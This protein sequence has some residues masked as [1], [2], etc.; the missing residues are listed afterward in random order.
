MKTKLFS[1][2]TL[3]LC[4][5]S[6]AWAETITVTWLPNDMTAITKAGTASVENI[7]TVSN[8][9]TSTDLADPVMA[10]YD[11]KNWGNFLCSTAATKNYYSKDDYITFAVT[12]A[13]NYKFY[14]T[15][16][17]A[18]AVGAGTGEGGAKIFSTIQTEDGQNAVI[19][20]KNA[21]TPTEL[22]LTT[23]AS[24]S[25]D[26]GSTLYFYIHV[27][28]KA[29]T[30]GICLRDVT[31]TGTYESANMTKLSTPSI[32]VN[33]L[34]GAVTISDID[35]NATKVTYTTD[36]TDPT[37]SST[38]Y[39]TQ[40]TVDA[41]CTVKAI[42]IGDGA[43]YSNSNI[44]IQAAA[45]TVE[46]PV[47]T[48]YNGT[49]GITCATDGATIKYNFDNGETW[50]TYT[51]PFTLFESQTV[52]TKAESA[53]YKNNSST[54]N[55]AVT[56]A[57]AA[58]AG[59]SSIALYYDDITNFSL[60]TDGNNDVLT[61]KVGTDYEGFSITLDN[62]GYTG[63][64]IKAISFGSSI[65]EKTTLKG[66]NGRKI[67]IALPSNLRA[68]RIT[69]KSY[70]NGS[71]SSTSLW[72]NVGGTAYTDANEI[73]LQCIS[74]ADNPDVRVFSLD[75]LTSI[76]IVNNGAQQQCF[77]AT[78]DYTKYIP[79]PVE[80]ETEY[81]TNRTWDFSA[82][83]TTDEAAL[84]ANSDAFTYD[85]TNKV[86][87]NK[88]QWTKDTDHALEGTDGTDI[89]IA[90]GLLFGRA[91]G[92]ISASGFVLDVKNNCFYYSSNSNNY[93]KLPSL[94]VGTKVSINWKA[95]GGK[96]TLTVDNATVASG[97]T[98]EAASGTTI[99]SIFD[100][101]S[102]DPVVIKFSGKCLVYSI[103][104]SVLAGTILTTTA[105]MAGYRAFYDAENSYTVDENTTVYVVSANSSSS[106]TLK[107]YEG[108]IP[109][110][111]PVI[112]KTSADAESDGTYKMTLT[113]STS[114]AAFSV[115]N[116]LN[117]S[118]SGQNLENVYRL[119]YGEDGVGFYKYTTSSAAAG[120]V[121][122]ESAATARSLS[123]VFDDETT[124]I[125]NIESSMLN[126]DGY[127]NL[128][129]QRV[130]QPRKGLY[131]VNGK[132]AII[133]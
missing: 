22:S 98:N 127:Y 10:T 56:A 27:G 23:F 86:Y 131:I 97:S 20:S 126:V 64:N 48:A 119:G 5:C 57:P 58:E 40:F 55:A 73:G 112:L 84:Q 74:D 11:S 30:K 89:S 69:I 103:S 51:I 125:N 6:G 94:S 111:T 14:P 26:G 71:I 118:T 78:V 61:G 32:S 121:Y 1:I 124:G 4:V 53:S 18:Y 115:T 133:K 63:S 129:G 60:N 50:N 19:N 3:L 52:Y 109:A 72:S 65:D 41:N 43:S 88:V 68:N 12:V 92:N 82:I 105:N 8:L 47:I 7:L 79:G 15:S 123:I 17:T 38:T 116:K 37:A 100:V 13:A 128:A 107:E 24:T 39:T 44:A 34:T 85:S 93:V 110:G 2:L 104:T 76:D 49:V 101:T 28:S 29:N 21:S 99:T 25:Y 16:V 70:N 80:P 122:V 67:T 130:A 33:Q 87:K 46:D 132:K 90:D 66:S 114:V 59:S 62:E 108:G 54:V 45:V 113:K 81:E 120:I 75:N 9:T 35:T 95:D 102:T 106:V 117:A 36:G 91:G 42:A 31:L 96:R 77:I 83:T